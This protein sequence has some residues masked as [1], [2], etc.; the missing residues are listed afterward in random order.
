MKRKF[1]VLAILLPLPNPRKI[2]SVPYPIQEGDRLQTGLLQQL[3][4]AAPA[5]LPLSHLAGKKLILNFFSLATGTRIAVFPEL[6]P[7]L[8]MPG[9]RVHPLLLASH[10]PERL[11]V[12]LGCA[13]SSID[14]VLPT[15]L[16]E[17]DRK[18]LLA[19]GDKPHLVCLYPSGEVKAIGEGYYIDQTNIRKAS[20]LKPTRKIDLVPPH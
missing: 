3:V 18:P 7:V 10:K 1:G 16:L 5:T 14:L 13:T 4:Q 11:D 2:L 6:E 15:G 9:G 19:F 20:G 17:K 8:Q 12:F